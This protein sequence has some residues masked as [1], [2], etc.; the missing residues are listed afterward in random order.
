MFV[1]FA[2]AFAFCFSVV[3]RKKMGRNEIIKDKLGQI[4]GTSHHEISH[5]A[6]HHCIAVAVGLVSGPNISL[7]H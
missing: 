6:H 5:I 4:S 1:V 7:I 2:F 3:V